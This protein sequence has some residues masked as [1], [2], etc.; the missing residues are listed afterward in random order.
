MYRG[1]GVTGYR[2]RAI[3][4]FFILPRHAETPT[5][6]Y[7]GRRVD[8]MDR[9]RFLADRMLGSLAKKLRLLGIDTAYAGDA[10]DSELKYLVR[11]QNRILLTRNIDLSR[12]L[13]DLAWPV[14]GKDIREE[15]LS[16]AEKLKPFCDLLVPFSRC[17]ECNNLLLSM[18]P[19]EAQGKVPPFIYQSQKIFTHCPS[20]GKVFW[21]GT[22]SER[23][24]EVVRWMRGAMEG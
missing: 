6:R 10:D 17:L 4:V 11:N 20:C 22:H 8:P 7:M 19:T 21:K 1:F 3:E 16:I 14:T 13:D 15:F 24:E 9:P 2:R 5:P 23:M 12:S 18:D